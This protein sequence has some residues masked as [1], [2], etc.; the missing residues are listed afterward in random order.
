MNLKKKIIPAYKVFNLNENKNN[1][2]FEG[3]K[4]SSKENI[5][6][7]IININIDNRIEDKIIVYEND[8]PTFL[9]EKF[10]LK[11]CKYYLGLKKEIIPQLTKSIEFKINNLLTSIKEED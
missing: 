9:A 3:P 6:L 2:K 8:K 4:H 10:A 7:L 1:D 5:P 11:H